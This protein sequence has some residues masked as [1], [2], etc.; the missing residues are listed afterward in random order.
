MTRTRTA[1]RSRRA[2]GRISPC[3]LLREGEAIGVDR[4]PPHEARPVLRAPDRC[5]L[6]TFADQ[7]VIAIENARLFEELEQRNRRARA[8][9]LEQQTATAEILRV[10]ASSPRPQPVLTPSSGAPPASAAP[11]TRSSAQVD[12]RPHCVGVA[13]DGPSPPAASRPAD[14]PRHASPGGVLERASDDPHP[15]GSRDGA[16]RSRIPSSPGAG[17]ATAR[18]PATPLLRDGRGDRR[19]QPVRYERASV[20]GCADR[21]AGDVRGPGRHRDR[22]RPALRGAGAAQRRAP[23][24]QSPGH[25]G[26]RAADRDRRV[27][28]VIATRRPISPHVL[29]AVGEN[30]A[31][32]VRCDGRHRVRASTVP[33]GCRC[34]LSTAAVP[35]RARRRAIDATRSPARSRRRADARRTSHDL[36]RGRRTVEWPAG[37]AQFTRSTGIGRSLAVPLLRDGRAI[38][39]IMSIRRR[40]SARSPSGR[41]RCWRR[42]P[43]RPSSRSR[44]RGCSSELQETNRQLEVASQHKSAVPGEH[45]PRAADPA[46]RHHR[47]LRDAPGGGRGP[48][49][50]GVHPGPPEDQRG[51]QAPAGADQRHPRPLQDRGRPDGPLPGDVRA[52]PARDAT[53]RRSSSR[54]WRRTATRWSSPAPTTSAP[55]TPTRPRSGRRCSTCSR[56][57]PSSPT[58]APSA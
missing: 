49:R 30:A 8:E 5:C 9:A 48:R 37:R 17:S 55:C 20:H 39:A 29:D 33:I 47:L 15:D 40:K 2:F 44:T 10:I 53:W 36:S 42:S 4:R 12:G 56:T 52:S 57:P 3:R 16:A 19:A 43:T 45:V 41:S 21:A 27:L 26:A 58:T 31:R 18:K 7:A 22:E 23:G 24:E 25:R 1:R 46:Q 50:G 28:R 6:E 35:N 32:T 34:E 54:W 14:R 51:R 38:G 11:T 13:V